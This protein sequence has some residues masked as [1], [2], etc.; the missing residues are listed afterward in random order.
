MDGGQEMGMASLD[1]CKLVTAGLVAVV[2]LWAPR[3]ASADPVALTVNVDPSLQQIMNRPCVIGDPSCHNPDT[4]DYTL[5]GPQ[6]TDATL[7]SPSY[8]VQQIRDLVGDT[9]SVNLDLNQA[10]GQNG[11][12]YDLIQF[13]MSVNGVVAFSTSSPTTIMPLAVGNGYSDASIAG[14]RLAGLAPTDK[15]VFTTT[16]TGAGAG[17]EQ[18][19]L[20]GTASPSATPEPAS[21]ILLGTG[22]AGA[23]VARRRARRAK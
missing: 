18:Y 21:M 6:T 2:A 20:G 12:A 13:T 9:F 15:I 3:P 11:G 10:A 23:Y 4:F 19:F 22:L 8:T 5:I 16:F 7:N 17:R 14:F 1:K